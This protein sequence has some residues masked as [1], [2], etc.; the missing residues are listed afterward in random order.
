MHYQ[1]PYTKPANRPPAK[2]L[3]GARVPQ[4]HAGARR[5]LGIG[6]EF[7]D[8]TDFEVLRVRALEQQ[9]V[10]EQAVQ[11]LYAGGAHGLQSKSTDANGD[12][13]A[14]DAQCVRAQ[15]ANRFE[16]VRD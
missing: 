9:F 2:Q 6:V 5:P 14:A 13:I 12:R 7:D 1:P 3:P 15:H 11:A 8:A 10:L 4:P 16:G